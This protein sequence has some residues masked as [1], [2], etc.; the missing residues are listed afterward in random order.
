M[1]KENNL[2]MFKIKQKFNQINFSK[3]YKILLKNKMILK[4]QLKMDYNHKKINYYI[5]NNNLFKNMIK[6]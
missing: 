4:I 3:V 2:K 6:I 1:K 5:M